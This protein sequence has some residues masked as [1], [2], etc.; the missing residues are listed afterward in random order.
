SLG[1]GSTFMAYNQDLKPTSNVTYTWVSGNHSMKFG[2]DLITEGIIVQNQSR[3][4]GILGFGTSQTGLGTFENGR[5]L[6]STTGFAYASFLLGFTNSETIAPLAKFR[7]GNHSLAFYAQD[8]W[9]V[10][11]KLTLN[12]GLRWDFVTLLRE[13]YGRMQSANFTKPNPLLNGK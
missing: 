12:Y 10:T 11:R 7:M 1:M 5:G 13:Q 9:K 4:N 2:A 8:S 6:N 3:S